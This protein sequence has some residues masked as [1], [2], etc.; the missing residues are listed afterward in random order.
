[1]PTGAVFPHWI[2]LRSNELAVLKCF[3]VLQS[4]LISA[5]PF[6]SQRSE[7][8]RWDALPVIWRRQRRCFALMWD[9]PLYFLNGPYRECHALNQAHH[10]VYRA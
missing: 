7:N 2:L 6:S 1:M 3:G 9:E 8:A 10:L 5:N 4:H